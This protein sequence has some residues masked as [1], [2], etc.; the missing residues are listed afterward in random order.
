LSIDKVALMCYDSSTMLLEAVVISHKEVQGAFIKVMEGRERYKPGEIPVDL[1]FGGDTFKLGYE[2]KPSDIS[3]SELLRGVGQCAFALVLGVKPYLVISEGTYRQYIDVITE[4]HWLSIVTYNDSLEFITK[5]DRE[6]EIAAD[7]KLVPFATISVHPLCEK[8]AFW[9][10][11]TLCCLLKT[12]R[13]RYNKCRSYQS[14]NDEHSNRFV[15]WLKEHPEKVSGSGLMESVR[16]WQNKDEL[17][18]I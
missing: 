13:P 2:I 5:L 15:K 9:D 11:G 14:A 16:Y 6:L 10:V 18:D 8:C 17:P 12:K 3:K 1:V 7:S 4:I